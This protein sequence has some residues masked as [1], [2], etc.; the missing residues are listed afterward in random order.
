MHDID[1][2]ILGKDEL[3]INFMDKHLL[4]DNIVRSIMSLDVT[5][6]D[7]YM[8]HKL[9]ETVMKLEQGFNRE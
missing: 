4:E 9:V 1:S 8:H 6:R 3:I 5:D 7:N 2:L